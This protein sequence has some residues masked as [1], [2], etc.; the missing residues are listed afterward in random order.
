[1]L[2]IHQLSDQSA[3]RTVGSVTF[4]IRDPSSQ[5]P[6]ELLL[7]RHWMVGQGSLAGQGL[8]AEQVCQ[9]SPSQSKYKIFSNHTLWTD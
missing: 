7:A 9:G 3:H 8:P 1:M 6:I 5:L 4:W 2:D